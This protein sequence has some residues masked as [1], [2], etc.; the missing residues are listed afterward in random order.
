M[1]KKKEDDNSEKS[2]SRSREKELEKQQGST[3][4]Q[5]K[6]GSKKSKEIE[7]KIFDDKNLIQ[8]PSIEKYIEN[9]TDE[10]TDSEYLK[11]NDMDQIRLNKLLN[12]YISTD[13]KK[14]FLTIYENFQFLLTYEDRKE[15][16]KK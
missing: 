11:K 1:K 10:I 14:D 6:K 7:I 9:L 16:Q 4:K 5:A 2:R 3:K 15:Y 13:Q 12:F 8:I